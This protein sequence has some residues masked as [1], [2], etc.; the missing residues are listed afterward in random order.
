VSKAE[1]PDGAGPEDETLEARATDQVPEGES[2]SRDRETPQEGE[3]PPAPWPEGEAELLATP[4]SE[5]SGSAGSQR[6]DDAVAQA[7]AVVEADIAAIVAQRDEYLDALRRLQADFENY[8][9][10]TIKQ[11][12]DHLERAAQDLVVK[13][14]PVLDAAD[15]AIAHGGGESV[16]QVGQLLLDTLIKEGLEGIAPEPDEP[17]DPTQHEAVVHE[18]GDGEAVIVELLRAGYRWKGRLLRAAMVKVKG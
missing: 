8:K 6:G 12:T 13:L 14:L 5:R 11:Q 7:E 16:A 9:K 1:F 3:A 2:A 4:G 10:R 18:P 17:F 15:L